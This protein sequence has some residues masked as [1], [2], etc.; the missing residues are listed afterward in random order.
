MYSCEQ[1]SFSFVTS[2]TYQ[3]KKQINK[4]IGITV[5]IHLME[6]TNLFQDHVSSVLYTDGTLDSVGFKLQHKKFKYNLSDRMR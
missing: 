3:T 1:H 2:T 6:V 5:M 4:Y